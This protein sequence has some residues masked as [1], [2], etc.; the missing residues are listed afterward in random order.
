MKGR[1]P[2]INGVRPINFTKKN[3]IRSRG[4]AKKKKPPRESSTRTRIGQPSL[5]RHEALRNL[6]CAKLSTAWLSQCLKVAGTTQLSYTTCV[7]NNNEMC[8]GWAAAAANTDWFKRSICFSP[9]RLWL[10]KKS[11]RVMNGTYRLTDRTPDLSHILRKVPRSFS[12][13]ARSTTTVVQGFSNYP[14]LDV[15]SVQC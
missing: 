10:I 8:T 2:P 14:L 9:W 15:Y 7:T 11:L 1:L 5:E 12:G 3:R 6:I 4:H 13:T